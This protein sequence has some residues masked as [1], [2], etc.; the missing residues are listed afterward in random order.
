MAIK[1]FI[2][3][4]DGVIFDTMPAI[5]S[6]F[7]EAMRPFD[8]SAKEVSAYCLGS[9]GSPI[10]SQIQGIMAKAKRSFDKDDVRIINNNFWE[11][12]RG[13][14]VKTFFG[15]KETLDNLKSKN[16]FLLASSGSKT[17]E[18]NRLF[19]EFN[20]SFDFFLGSDKIL[21]GDEHI[22]IFA[23]HFSL[24]KKDFCRQAA[25][26]GDGTVDMQI[27]SRNGIF[28]IGITNSLP[29]DQL[30]AAGAQNIVAK[31]SDVLA[32]II[33]KDKNCRGNSI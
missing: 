16:I 19:K 27:A 4:M 5:L 20:L 9:L 29:A 30:L 15:V 21:K 25:F 33:R 8:F 11:L 6:A 32:I 22:R 12:M 23:E 10:E 2:T 26:I 14:P 1:Y 31:F 18:M 28:A 24:P 13:Q 3:D 7:A 17:A